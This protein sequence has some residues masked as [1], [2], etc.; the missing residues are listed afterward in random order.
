MKISLKTIYTIVIFYC[1][2]NQDAKANNWL[3]S[4]N[5]AYKNTNYSK[6][7]IYYQKLET[8]GFNNPELKYNIGNSYYNLNQIGKSIL[9]YERALILNPQF[10]DAQYNLKLANSFIE[11][12][13]EKVPDFNFTVFF[14]KLNTFIS[15]DILAYSALIFI[16]IACIILLLKITHKIKINYW[17]S[18]VLFSLSL[19]FGWLSIEQNKALKNWQHAIVMVKNCN[20]LSAPSQDGKILFSIHEGTKVQILNTLDRVNFEI[21][22]PNGLVGW[23]TIDEI[24]LVQPGNLINEDLSDNL[25]Q[26]QD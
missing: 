21:K 6:A 26:Y 8:D 2:F 11:D 17:W 12:E 24:E 4:A 1:I 3:D 22:T 19:V 9:Y 23:V 20:V 18:F 25:M 16:V 15:S 13:F 7:L 5:I 14:F 10:K